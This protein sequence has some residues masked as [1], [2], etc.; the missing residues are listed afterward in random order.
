MLPT[1]G[2]MSLLAIAGEFG[3]SAPYSISNYYRGGSH[4]LN[5]TNNAPIPTSG[6]VSF[7]QYYGTGNEFFTLYSSGVTLPSALLS[8]VAWNGTRYLVSQDTTGSSYFLTYSNNG[9]GTSWTPSNS[10]L[11]SS[12]TTRDVASDGTQFGVS[13]YN[14]G[15]VNPIA[16]SSTGT[17]SWTSHAITGWGSGGAAVIAYGGGNWVLFSGNKLATSTNGTTWTN[18][19]TVG[20]LPT[21]SG[22]V[23]YVG[24]SLGFVTGNGGSAG[25]WYSL[26]GVTWTFVSASLTNFIF[27]DIAYNGSTYVIVGEN[28]SGAGAVY[29]S[30]TPTSAWTIASIP[31]TTIIN[32]CDYGNGRFVYGTAGG[33]MASSS[34]GATFT[35]FA[36]PLTAGTDSIDF[37]KYLNSNF[38][39][40]GNILRS[41]VQYIG[42]CPS[43]DVPF[44][45]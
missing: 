31:D 7:S 14:G 32:C 3:G 40:G 29:H 10:P 22:G 2:P 9:A 45:P 24:G 42:V 16:T 8:N 20:A 23:K 36:T 6:T 21:K 30:T 41:S 19:G 11:G 37:I 35:R 34:A 25:F 15:T 27:Q 18:R 44:M 28:G 33:T 39:M 13:V 12:D 38:V 1:S 43:S 26:V 4:V 17:G 5:I